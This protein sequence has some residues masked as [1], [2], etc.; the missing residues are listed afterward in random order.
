MRGETTPV[1]G[2]VSTSDEFLAPL[3]ATFIAPSILYARNNNLCIYYK[4]RMLRLESFVKEKKKRKR[5]R[6]REGETLDEE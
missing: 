5:E 3:H 2:L 4:G 1:S 6:E